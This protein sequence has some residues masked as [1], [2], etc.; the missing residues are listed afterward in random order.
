VGATSGVP[1]RGRVLR[2]GI[3][4]GIMAGGFINPDV[5]GAILVAIGAD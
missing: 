1:V 2:S 5:A 4:N 3:S